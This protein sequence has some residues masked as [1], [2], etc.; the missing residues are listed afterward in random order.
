MDKFAV[1]YLTERDKGLINDLVN[2]AWAAGA[3]KN[4]QMAQAV[5]DLRAKILK[6]KEEKPKD[7][8]ETA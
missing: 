2:I 1:D 7:K 5:E 3:V 4:P 6:P 8:K